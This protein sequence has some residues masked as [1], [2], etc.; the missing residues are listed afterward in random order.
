M[1]RRWTEPIL[2]TLLAA[3]LLPGGDRIA[4]GQDRVA[5]WLE[6]RGMY[7]LLQIHLERARADASD[8]AEL[9]AR[10]ASRLAG[11]YASLIERAT[12][13][14]ARAVLVA[15]A[16]RLLADDSIEDADALRL[17]LLRTRYEAASGTVERGRVDLAAPDEVIAAERELDELARDLVALRE[18]LEDTIK[19][20]DRG[21]DRAR[22]MRVIR[23]DDEITEARRMLVAASL[24]EG[25]SLYYA[26]RA[27]DDESRLGRAQ[28]AFG[29][30]LDGDEVVPGPDDVSVDR[31][32]Y[33][34]FASAI[35]GMAMTSAERV[36]HL[37]AGPWFSR[38]EL[39]RTHPGILQAVPGWRLASAI[40]AKSFEVAETLLRAMIEQ[41]DG[42]SDSDALPTAWLR[43]AAVGGLRHAADLDSG[44]RPEA[45]RLAELA[46][47]TLAAR[48]E[49]A[50]VV[51]LAERYGLGAVGNDG[52]AFRY[53]R[54]VG[55]YRAAVDAKAAGRA[56]EAATEFASAAKELADAAAERDAARFPE[57]RSAC[58]NLTG[59]SLL[60]LDRAADAADAFEDAADRIGGSRRA[61][62]MWGAIVA[63]DRLVAAGGDEAVEAQG[64]RDAIIERFLDTYP[65][66]DRAPSLVVRRITGEEDPSAADLETLLA[67][68]PGHATWE[69]AR[70]RAAQSIY[71]R[72]READPGDRGEFGTR[73]L[74]VADELLQRD[75]TEDG[76]MVDLRGADGVLLRQA[77]EVASHEEIG[78]RVRGAGYI[79]RLEIAL[80]RGGFEDQP[81]LPNELAFRRIG[82][83]IADGDFLAAA[84]ILQDVPVAPDAP[85]AVRWSRL[86]AQRLHRAAF[87]RMR[88]GEASMQVVRA[89]VAAGDR[90][91]EIV[92]GK[93]ASI[94]EALENPALLPV[95]ASVAAGRQAIYRADDD[96]ATGRKAFETYRAILERRPRDG[97]ILEASAELASSLGD[98][99]FALACWR[100]LGSAAS[101]GSETWWRARCGLLGV[102]AETD[103][104][105]AGEV[106]EQIRVLHPDFGPEPWRSRLQELDLEIS[107]RRGLRDEAD[108][109]ESFIEPGATP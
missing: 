39:A 53:V 40:D 88:D 65:A 6:G 69:I 48:S 81:D 37:G 52:F 95:A 41:A 74:D 30:V 51:D 82:M 91:I 54:G 89:A 17:A 18:S 12:D 21:L 47:A 3:V 2:A 77:A 78:D 26:G 87:L 108:R 35:L 36:S 49:L 50:Q 61:D 13:D 106:L 107:I 42:G 70:R 105:R 93:D 101:K 68:P 44:W 59:W 45:S 56:G 79:S 16:R 85:E 24:L 22:G 19:R 20:G 66:D 86:A 71:R 75:R 32:E 102:L 97:S 96:E 46:L 99:D 84:T 104:E 92:G 80:E 23:L 11:V 38:L 1:S 73:F 57:A 31:Q 63:L 109:D 67:I 90:F 9:R 60:E 29:R 55:H 76:M 33:E 34:Y 7:D 25:W 94:E 15:K 4:M 83:A 27:L 58:L 10:T 72:F 62:A 14:E 43:L 103:P 64:R 5:S 28:L 98:P 100:R 8:D